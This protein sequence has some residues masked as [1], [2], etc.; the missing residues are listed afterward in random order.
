MRYARHRSQL[1]KLADPSCHSEPLDIAGC[2]PD[3]LWHQLRTML[4][5]RVAEEHIAKLIIDGLAQCPCHLGIGQEA[6]AA[7]VSTHLRRGDRTFGAHRSHAHYLALGA[8]VDGLMAEVL[9]KATGCSRGMGGSMHLFAG[10]HGFFGSVPIVAGTVALAV[11]AGMAATMD[12]R[13][14]VAVVYFGDGA[15]E[16]GVVHESFNLAMR[17]NASVLFVCENNLYSS[18]LDISLRQPSDRIARYAEAHDIPTRVVDGNDVVAV[19]AAA[20]DSCAAIRAGGG[21]AFLEA[22]T[23]RW[24]G[25]VGADENIDVGVRRKAED[26]LAWKRRDPIARLVRA[27]EGIGLTAASLQ[28]ARDE[29]ERRVAEAVAAAK[30]APYPSES[31]LFNVVYAPGKRTRVQ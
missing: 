14:A 28:A 23:Y 16:E 10:Q 31:D 22:V 21:P 6:I 27:M 12:G 4:L 15:S 29:V 30:D 1:G 25:H 8:S 26:L 19:A 3:V 9:G 18:H 24:R 13:G 17:Y 20:R 2:A 5:I 7:G 11:G